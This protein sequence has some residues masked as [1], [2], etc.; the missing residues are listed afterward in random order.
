MS[1]YANNTHKRNATRCA[2]SK[3]CPLSASIL[4]GTGCAARNG[5]LVK[6]RDWMPMPNRLRFIAGTFGLKRGAVQVLTCR[7]PCRRRG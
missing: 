4:N 3:M 5:R 6:G 1:E 7:V 2:Q